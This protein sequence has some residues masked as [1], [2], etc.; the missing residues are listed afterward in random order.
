MPFERCKDVSVCKLQDRTSLDTI[1]PFRRYTGKM[2]SFKDLKL[3]LPDKMPKQHMKVTR[4]VWTGMTTKGEF[5]LKFHMYDNLVESLFNLMIGKN[6]PII[7]VTIPTLTIGAMATW[8][9]PVLATPVTS[10]LLS[11]FR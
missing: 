5:A 1:A 9:V 3:Q 8:T 4:E 10:K 7:G 2:P 11:T 6:F